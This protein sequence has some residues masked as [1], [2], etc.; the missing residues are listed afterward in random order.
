VV[1]AASYV[2]DASIAAK[3][4]IGRPDEPFLE[5]AYQVLRDYEDNLVQLVAPSLIRFE[6]GH[7]LRRAAIRERIS[8]EVAQLGLRRFLALPLQTID[9]DDLLSAGLAMSGRYLC[10]FYDG[11]YLAVAELTQYPLIHAD[12]RLHNLLGNRFHDAFWIGDSRTHC[13]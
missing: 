5:Q 8:W 13:S 12:E 1:E 4:L 3:W 10:S 7:A 11:L 6:L 2:L 9:T